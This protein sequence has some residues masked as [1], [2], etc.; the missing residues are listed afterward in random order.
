[1]NYT[2]NTTKGPIIINIKQKYELSSL[3]NLTSEQIQPFLSLF[4]INEIGD[5]GVVSLIKLS[6]NHNLIE[7]DVE[8]TSHPSFYQW[9][10]KASCEIQ[11]VMMKKGI[12]FNG[13]TKYLGIKVLL[14]SHLIV[15]GDTKPPKTS[16]TIT[17]PGLFPPIPHYQTP[18]DPIPQN[19]QTKPK[20]NQPVQNPRIAQKPDMRQS[21]TTGPHHEPLPERDFK[22]DA[23]RLEIR[24][25]VMN[26]CF[27]NNSMLT[28]F[29]GN[30]L[31]IIYHLYDQ[32][33]FN[34]ELDKMLKEKKRTISLGSGIISEHKAGDH[35]RNG[36]SHTIRVSSYMIGNLFSNGEKSIKANGMIIYDRFDALVTILEHEMVH[37]YCSLKGY[38]RKIKQG[39]GKMYYSPHGK[40]FQEMVFRFFGHTDFRHSFN[41]GEASEQLSR[42]DCRVGM[43]IYFVSIK[44]GNVYG[45]IIKINPKRCKVYSE[46]GSNYDVP[47]SIVRKSDRDVNVPV[48]ETHKN[49]KSDYSVGMKV[50]FSHNKKLVTATIIK[51]NPT[52]A[53]VE[54]ILG[55][56]NVPYDLLK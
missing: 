30:D 53:R 7:G 39:K 21:I 44:R 51:C 35:C 14:L 50:R 56:Y 28:S 13:M 31:E 47:Y 29:S 5:I 18:Q 6:S 11:G 36:N 24:N 20:N 55:V 32:H 54:S 12:W 10:S 43:Y 4:N 27:D 25:H 19:P 2:V 23:K 8:M 38:T 17:K 9:L 16:K 46:D 37:L 15:T 41:A 49:N 22:I 40:L 34:N 52:R 26:L 48:Q 42:N 45:K 3:L 1:M 33:C